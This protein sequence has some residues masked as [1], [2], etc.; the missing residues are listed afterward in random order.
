MKQVD[1][2]AALAMAAILAA[3]SSAW[4][5]FSGQTI[6]GP[7]GPG[8]VVFGDT[9]NGSTDDNDGITSGMHIFYIWTGPD[10]VYALNWPG[11]DLAL[12]MVY[13]NTLVDLDL[14]LYTPD[15]LD[16]SGNYSILNTGVEDIFAPASVAGTYYVL[17][18]APADNAGAY[19]LSVA[20]EPGTLALLGLGMAFIARRPR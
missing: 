17:V 20:P 1:L 2:F 13:N 11:G 8:S 15:N 3:P 5:D 4:A 14:F 6:L 7:L 10:D 16:D 18:D 12:Q 9:S 19:S